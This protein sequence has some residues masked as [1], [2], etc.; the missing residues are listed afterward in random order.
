MSVSIET[1]GITSTKALRQSEWLVSWDKYPGAM[2]ETV[3]GCTTI[4]FK[5]VCCLTVCSTQLSWTVFHSI[6][7]TLWNKRAWILQGTSMSLDC[8]LSSTKTTERSTKA[9]MTVLKLYLTKTRRKL[10]NSSRTPAH[11]LYWKNQ[12]LRQVFN[13]SDGPGQANFFQTSAEP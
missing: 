7:N 8:S 13:V 11:K 2:S 10:T 3:I 1:A 5:H 12:F 6:L 9:M 4:L